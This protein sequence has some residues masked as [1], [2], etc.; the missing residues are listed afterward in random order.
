V[1]VFQQPKGRLINHITTGSLRMVLYTK[2]LHLFKFEEWAEGGA[3]IS[4]GG[5]SYRAV[6]PPRAIPCGLA[7][8]LSICHS[9]TYQESVVTCKNLL[10]DNIAILSLLLFA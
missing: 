2:E 5:P 6:Q 1:Y 8:L 9:E 4:N 10:C 7:R 3:K